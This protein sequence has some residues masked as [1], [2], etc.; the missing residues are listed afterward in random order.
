MAASMVA[1][2][3]RLSCKPTVLTTAI[4]WYA[5]NFRRN[6]VGV[7]S[8][9]KDLE[10]FKGKGGLVR[11]PR[12]N[13]DIPYVLGDPTQS[14]FLLENDKKLSKKGQKNKSI[15]ESQQQSKTVKNS[16][17]KPEL[18]KSESRTDSGLLY[19][20]LEDGDKRFGYT[21]YIAVHRFYTIYSY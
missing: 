7:I 21:N 6:P 11:D 18:P 9:E 19:E 13:P 8:Q 5:K 3:S 1:C 16:L 15:S 20:K 17:K 12:K 2:V 4:R 10:L 14:Q